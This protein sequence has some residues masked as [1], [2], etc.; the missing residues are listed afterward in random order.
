MN[1]D[2]DC[3]PDTG[4]S[5]RQAMLSTDGSRWYV[6]DLG[7]SNGTYLGQADQPL[8]TMPIS[9]RSQVG[10]DDRIY[11]GSWTRLVVR[12]ALPSEVSL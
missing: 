5:R 3:D 2:I 8:P 9:G 1:P 10:A 12:P 6:E 4:V 11:V 7:S